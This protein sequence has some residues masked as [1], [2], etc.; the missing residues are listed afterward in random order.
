ME[1][2]RMGEIIDGLS[3]VKGT[4]QALSQCAAA[5][6]GF[7]APESNLNEVAENLQRLR[8]N[9]KAISC[10][11]SANFA[12]QA[13]KIVESSRE[14]QEGTYYGGEVLWG[15]G[16]L[17]TGRIAH[18]FQQ[19][20]SVC[21]AEIETKT[22]II[23]DGVDVEFYIPPSPLFGEEVVVAFP[24]S[25]GE[26]DEA[27]KCLALGRW[28]AAVMHLMR[29][30]EP[31][32]LALQ[33]DVNVEHPKEQWHHVIDQIEAKIRQIKK[34]THGAEDEKWYSDAAIQFR[35]IKDG[36]RNYS[37]HLH[38]RYDKERAIDIFNATKALMRQLATR[39]RESTD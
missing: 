21:P 13:L 23:L 22:I 31:A 2:V 8:N 26:I 3:K 34:R 30:L 11:V 5:H 7:C 6:Q 19:I 32:L 17:D 20:G 10:I 33:R 16:A 12:E 4:G 25:A 9:L 27:G 28:T 38:E 15:W 14:K 29:A 1:L 36:W 18:L 37:Q 39:L 35:Y 24:S